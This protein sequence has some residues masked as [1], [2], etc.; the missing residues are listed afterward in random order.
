MEITLSRKYFETFLQTL[1]GN[2][3]QCDVGLNYYGCK[4][5]YESRIKKGEW[6]VQVTYVVA[7]NLELSRGFQL[8]L[9]VCVYIC[10]IFED[11]PG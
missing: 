6:E 8:D 5:R 4:W 11:E 1:F 3:I 7:K 9:K 2:S 10:G